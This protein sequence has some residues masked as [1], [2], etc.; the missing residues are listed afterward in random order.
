FDSPPGHALISRIVQCYVPYVP[1]DYVLEGVGKV[2]DG[3]DLV[4]ITPTGSGKTGYMAFTALVMRELSASPESYLHLKDIIKKFPKHPLMLAI[5]PTDYLEYQMEENFA[6]ISLNILV[7]NNDTLQAARLNKHPELWQQA[8][9]NLSL[10]IILISPEQLKSKSYEAA[11]MNDRF[12]ERIYA[13]TVDEVHLLLTWGKSF[14]KPFQQIGL[15]KAR[16]PDNV[17][18][19][20]LT[21]TMQ[22]GS[23]LH[24]ICRFLG[25]PE[26][27]YHLIRRSNQRPDIQLIFREISSPVEGL[28]FPELDWVLKE[29]RNTIIFARRIHFGNR[30]H[31][32]MYHQ[33]K[34]SGGDPR[35]VL[36]R[37]RE[38]TSLS[39][40]YNEQTR[41]FMQSGDCLVVFATSSLA[42][43][44]DVDNVQDV[45]VFGDPEDVNE[46]IQMI[47]RIRPRWQQSGNRPTHRGIIYFFPNASERA[48]RAIIL[49]DVTASSKFSELENAANE[50]D[51]GLAQLYRARCKTAEIDAQFQ[52]PSNDK[53]CQCPT[54]RNFPFLPT[55]ITCICSGC[56]PEET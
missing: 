19:L 56:V 44:V 49:K 51:K 17:R 33:D 13:M 8:Q 21:A 27:K 39:A 43:G 32:Y 10:S 15:A 54:C 55:Q 23:A 50:M 28:F 6:R 20:A 40:E 35:T 36:K 2:L 42:V 4:A 47:G 16:L 3:S 26:G 45:I 29:K 12:Y 30:I 52:N 37:M 41:V 11:L 7:I 24:S 18:T 5:C 48:E 53:L 9:D 14:R 46:L 1:H 22:V 38:Y 31:E 25:M 34:K